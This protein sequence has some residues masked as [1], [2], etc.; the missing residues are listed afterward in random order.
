MLVFKFNLYR[1]C[2]VSEWYR[3]GSAGAGAGGGGADDGGGGEGEESPGP[4]REDRNRGRLAEFLQPLDPG[5]WNRRA[6]DGWTP[7]GVF[8]R[9]AKS[10]MEGEFH[11]TREV[12]NEQGDVLRR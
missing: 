10:A 2:V 12:E 11:V 9:Y 4:S 5:W 8:D 1:Y 6:S 3:S 7:A